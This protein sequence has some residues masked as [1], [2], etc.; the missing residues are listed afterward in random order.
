MPIPDPIAFTIF[1]VDIRWYGVLIA[2]AIG[3]AVALTCLRAPKHN[4]TAD[5][6]L[7]VLIFAIPGGILGA[8]IYYVIFEWSYYGQHL[9]QI[10]N[11][12]GGGLAIHGG[13]IGSFL[14]AYLV[15]RRKKLDFLDALDLTVPTIALAQAIGRWGNYFNSE[16]H[17]GPTDLPW[18]IT[19]DGVKVH[20]TFLYESIWCFLLFFVLLAIDNRRTFVGQTICWYGI[21]YSIERILVESLRTDSLMIGPFKQAQV[22]SACIILLAIALMVYCRRQRRIDTAA[23]LA[24]GHP[25]FQTKKD[26]T[27]V[28]K[29]MKYPEVTHEP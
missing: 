6:M 13:L 12:R 18:A 25:D 4:L 2:C 11:F 16:A 19:V 26:G 10:L 9:D 28:R 27:P 1:G 3:I 15:C 14:V 21:L 23:Y 5:Q 17:G 29:A 7:D 8:R 22:L 24:G 20:P